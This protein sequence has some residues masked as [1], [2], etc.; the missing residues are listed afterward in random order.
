MAWPIAASDFNVRHTVNPTRISVMTIAGRRFRG[1]SRAWRPIVGE[2]DGKAR[3]FEEVAFE[4]S[5]MGIAFKDEDERPHSEGGRWGD[6]SR[7]IPEVRHIAPVASSQPRL[8]SMQS[9]CIPAF[10]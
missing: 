3:L 9:N 1:S 7:S 2:L 10:T 5:Y 6:V 4:A 8:H